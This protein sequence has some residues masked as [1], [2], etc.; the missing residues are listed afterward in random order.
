MTEKEK[1]IEGKLYKSWD[2]ELVFDRTRARQI[3]HSFNQSKVTEAHN[4][5][6]LLQ[7]LLGSAGD[8]AAIEPA[9]QC[10]YGYNIH[11]GDQFF[12]NFNCVFL[13]VC[14]IKIGNRVMMGPNVQIYTATHP[15]DRETRASGLEYGKPVYIGD[16][17]W[18]GGSAVINPGVTIG[19]NVV[20]GSGAV[21]TKD[22]PANVF[23]GGN[24][25]KFIKTVD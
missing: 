15:M 14:K 7:S 4:R 12:A 23:V 16:D 24:P 22:V 18:V 11:V 17:V 13:D 3:L 5:D 21:V 20:I 9:F 19:N 8:E 10:D 6:Q 2:D 25:A 1:M